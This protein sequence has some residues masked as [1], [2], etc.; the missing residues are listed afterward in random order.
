MFVYK[1]HTESL[2]V[3]HKP[4]CI[5]RL[6]DSHRPRAR[7]RRTQH[8][9]GI[10]MSDVKPITPKALAEELGI[11]PKRLRGWLRSSDFARPAEA[12]N[13]TWALT[14]DVADAARARFAPADEE[15]KAEA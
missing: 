7:A 14:P 13:T 9:K 3:A 4:P 10:N 15:V 1:P 11:D 12:K 8:R 6:V 2:R 5:L